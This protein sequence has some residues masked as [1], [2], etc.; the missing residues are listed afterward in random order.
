MVT[1]RDVFPR[2]AA[3]ATMQNSRKCTDRPHL[4]IRDV[5]DS[6]ESVRRRSRLEWCPSLTAIGS[7]QNDTKLCCT[8]SVVCIGQN[9]CPR[10]V[11]AYRWSEAHC[12]LELP[13]SLQRRL[14]GSVHR[15]RRPPSPSDHPAYTFRQ[16]LQQHRPAGLPMSDRRSVVPITVPASPT[17]QPA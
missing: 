2:C 9:G 5:L 17:A 12:S 10:S 1:H 7:L 3:I 15:Y 13:M 14:Y 6:I 8:Q 4:L 11:P 16:D